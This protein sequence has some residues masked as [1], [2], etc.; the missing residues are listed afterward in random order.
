MSPALVT[1]ENNMFFH[2]CQ[3][4]STWF[5]KTKHTDV[6]RLISRLFVLQGV[7]CAAASS[8]KYWGS[9]VVLPQ[10]QSEKPVKIMLCVQWIERFMSAYLYNPEFSIERRKRPDNVIL[11]RRRVAL[12]SLKTVSVPELVRKHLDT[13]NHEYLFLNM[14]FLPAICVLSNTCK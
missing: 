12:I 13:F 2:F 4:A 1:T 7:F 3:A 9:C 8:S 6:R 11:Q 10:Q 5:N 14:M